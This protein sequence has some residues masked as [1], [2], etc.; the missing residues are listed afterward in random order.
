MLL[1]EAEDRVDVGFAADRPGRGAWHPV[2][3]GA[4][5]HDGRLDGRHRLR[6]CV[7]GARGGS[8]LGAQLVAPGPV[9]HLEPAQR[10]AAVAVLHVLLDQPEVRLLVERLGSHQLG[11]APRGAEQLEVGD[12]EALALGVGPRLVE[13]LGQQVAAVEVDRLRDRGG[14]ARCPVEAL[15]VHRHLRVGQQRDHVAGQD[16]R[17]RDPDGRAGVVRGLVQPRRRL[18]QEQVGPEEVHQLLTWQLA[19]RPEREH[20][21]QRGGAAAGPGVRGD[22]AAVDDDREPSQETDVDVHRTLQPRAMRLYAGPRARID[23]ISQRWPGRTA[24][25]ERRRPDRA[26]RGARPRRPSPR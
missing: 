18:L 16:D 15:D 1:E 14:V 8:G 23:A 10:L 21:D 26:A 24:L 2:G 9:H 12:A 11:P 17:G 7:E 20:L 3:I 13:V 25:S 19:A 22:R 4:R 5:C 6:A